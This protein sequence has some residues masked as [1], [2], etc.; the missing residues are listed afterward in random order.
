MVVIII[1]IIIIIIIMI[2]IIPSSSPTS[3][4][5]SDKAASLG[6]PSGAKSLDLRLSC[7]GCSCLLPNLTGTTEPLLACDPLGDLL[8]GEVASSPP[9]RRGEPSR[10][11]DPS[12]AALVLLDTCIL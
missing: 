4:P 9:S 3:S 10:R 7:E 5:S 11:G 8:V 6:S 2:I 12:L 1:I